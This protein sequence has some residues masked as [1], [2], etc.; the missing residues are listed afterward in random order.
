MNIR[1]VTIRK[2]APSGN[3]MII[4][5]LLESP[6]TKKIFK[7][8][9]YL[10]MTQ[11]Q[12]FHGWING[13]IF[14]ENNHI[15]KKFSSMV[16]VKKPDGST[17]WCVDYRT[18]NKVTREKSLSRFLLLYQYQQSSSYSQ[19]LSP[20]QEDYYFYCCFI[21]SSCI[22]LR[23]LNKNGKCIQHHCFSFFFPFPNIPPDSSSQ[24]LFTASICWVSLL[25]QNGYESKSAFLPTYLCIVVIL[26]VYTYYVCVLDGRVGVRFL[27]SQTQNQN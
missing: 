11:K 8:S 13:N 4:K 25:E 14:M 1:V 2:L 3:R 24:A 20:I 9:F 12:E 27:L 17:R 26:W 16:P 23:C 18:I 10:N 19:V 6:T 15:F 22:L 21:L 7:D 5:S